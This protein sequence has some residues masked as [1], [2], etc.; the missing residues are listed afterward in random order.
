MR[1]CEKFKST[2]LFYGISFCNARV[3]GRKL[4]SFRKK[5]NKS[6]EAF[7]LGEIFFVKGKQSFFWE[8][9]KGVRIVKSKLKPKCHIKS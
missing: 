8:V 1:I 6:F 7:A 4:L 3:S 2:P 9:I 5:Y